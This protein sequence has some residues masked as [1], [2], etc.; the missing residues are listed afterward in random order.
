M[1]NP[2]LWDPSVQWTVKQS[3]TKLRFAVP[4][5]RGPQELERL[6]FRQSPQLPVTPK[7][8]LLAGPWWV[9]PP[10]RG[11]PEPEPLAFQRSPKLPEIRKSRERAVLWQH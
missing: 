4:P 9:E 8:R 7:R 10:S 3:W 2:E 5:S 11:P 1:K 6:I